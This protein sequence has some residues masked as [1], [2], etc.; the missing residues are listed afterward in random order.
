[1]R[2][3]EVGITLEIRRDQTLL[4]THELCRGHHQTLLIPTHHA[5]IPI[6]S[7]TTGKT[8]LTLSVSAPQVEVRSLSEYE[9][10]VEE[11]AA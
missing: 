5:G 1:M 3:R 6:A 4:C 11:V 7:A 8:R 2:L 10:L 9:V